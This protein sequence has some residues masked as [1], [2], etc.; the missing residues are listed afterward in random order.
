MNKAVNKFQGRATC[1]ILPVMLTGMYASSVMAQENISRMD[2]I[3]VTGTK[4]QHTLKDVPVQT[5]VITQEEIEKLPAQNI[6]DLLKTVP[7]ISTSL[8]D[9]AMGSDNLRSTFRGLQF[10]EGYALIL[11]DGQRVHG[12]LGAHGDYG[13]SLTQIP[14]SMIE[15]IEIVK[16]ASSSLYGADA[17]AGV[18]NVITKK[19]PEKATGSAG[20]KHGR[21]EMKDRDNN[22]SLLDD[23]RELSSSYVSYG[24]KVGENS[25]YYVHLSSESDQDVRAQP[26]DTRR[27]TALLKWQTRVSDNWSFD[28]GA[29]VSKARRDPWNV[30]AQYDREFDNKRYSAGIHWKKDKHAASFKTYTYDQEFVQGYEGFPHGYRFGDIGYDQAEVMY[31]FYGDQHLLTIGAETL[32]QDMDYIFNNYRDDALEATVPV[33]EKITT[34]SVYVQDE[35]LLMGERLRLVPG[36]RFEDH[37]TFGSEL[38]PKFSLMH[39]T[40]PNTTLRASVG[41]AF[42]SPTIRQL[43][44]Q[45][46]Y[47]H[48]SNYLESNPDLDPETAI[49]W[50]A[51]LEHRMMDNKLELGLG[52]FRTD[53][54]DMVIR[55]DTGRVT[56]DSVPIYSYQNIN[57]AQIQG[58]EL[59]VRATPSRQFS[60]N[61]GLSYTDGENKDSGNVLPYVPEYNA[62]IVPTYFNERLATG[63]S[64]AVNWFDKQYR[65]SSNTR[66]VDSYTTADVRLWKQLSDLAK[67]SLDVKNI[68]SSDKGDSEFNWRAGRSIALALDVEF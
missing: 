29:E 34:N 22:D 12:G 56:G 55:Y 33:K 2:E 35:I 31:N 18:I 24:D 62:S 42:K 44:Y 19:I 7:G 26:N 60:V 6:T 49:S 17:L 8:L 67:V 25:G 57:E 41:K 43:Y 51:H 13:V 68:T 61:A 63:V 16:G 58:L 54:E 50:T 46:I 10:N 59:T 3:V 20:F 28:L 47:R 15:R 39:L 64:G 1:L 38:N 48:G 45:G 37:S 52:L 66:E 14:V 65:N 11:I 9:D 4:T 5:T 27:D 40:T 36:V 30:A 21:Y 23:S 53:V 32:V